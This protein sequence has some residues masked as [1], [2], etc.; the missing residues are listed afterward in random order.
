MKVESGSPVGAELDLESITTPLDELISENGLYVVIDVTAYDSTLHNAIEPAT[1]TLNDSVVEKRL[2]VVSKTMDELKGLKKT[3]IRLAFDAVKTAFVLDGNSINWSGGF[4]SA[5]KMDAAKRMAQMA[6]LISV[7]L[8]D[9]ANIEHVL[10]FAEAEVVILTIGADYQTKFA[11]KQALMVV[12]DA[13]TDKAG[14]D[15][16]TVSF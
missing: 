12:A 3:S 13:A 1:Y 9:A 16:I 14:L 6:G 2:T 8:F 4:D 10:S 11:Q 15:A 5:L 7:S